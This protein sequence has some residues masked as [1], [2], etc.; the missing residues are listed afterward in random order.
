MAPLALFALADAT[1]LDFDEPIYR[2]L[3]W[4]WGENELGVNLCDDQ[5]AVI[6]RCIRPTRYRKYSSEMLALL[7]LPPSPGPL[8]VLYE[9]RPYHLGWLLYAF[10]GRGNAW[11][12]Q[13]R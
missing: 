12:A 7:H 5:D 3:R 9:S 2:G 13:N 10:A 11:G 8:H 1:G 4:I 6:W